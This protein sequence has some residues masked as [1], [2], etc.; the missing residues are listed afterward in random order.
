MGIRRA[1]VTWLAVIKGRPGLGTHA[2]YHAIDAPPGY[3]TSVTQSARMCASIDSELWFSIF[4]T[5]CSLL[6]QFAVSVMMCQHGVPPAPAA[7]HAGRIVSIWLVWNW[8]VTTETEQS[9]WRPGVL[10]ST[11]ASLPS[12]HGSPITVLSR[13]PICARPP[14]RSFWQIDTNVLRLGN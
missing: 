6:G 11:S 9:N 12:M 3:C 10:G 13:S 5:K 4:S 1:R 7:G 8:L 14:D 2:P